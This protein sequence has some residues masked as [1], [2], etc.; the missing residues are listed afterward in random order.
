MTRQVQS[1]TLSC[2]HHPG[3][4]KVCRAGTSF[5]SPFTNTPPQ[6]WK[7]GSSWEALGS[8]D[9][10][11]HSSLAN[12]SHN[13]FTIS[14]YSGLSPPVCLALAPTH[15]RRAPFPWEHNIYCLVNFQFPGTLHLG[16]RCLKETGV[17][18]ELRTTDEDH[19]VPLLRISR[20]FRRE[21]EQQSWL[22]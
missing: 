10:S 13:S 6:R 1:E 4:Q 21:Q 8:P 17:G 19:S 3:E 20:A 15:G 16:Q 5:L 14:Q 12:C 22:V 7:A 9:N 11:R 2:S 18:V